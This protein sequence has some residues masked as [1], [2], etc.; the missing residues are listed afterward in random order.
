MATLSENP[1]CTATTTQCYTQLRKEEDS[2]F[3]KRHLTRVLYLNEIPGAM[4]KMG[5]TVAAKMMRHWFENKPWKMPP[6]DRGA[7]YDNDRN[8]PIIY[9]K[10]DP[11][12]INEDIITMKWARKF[13]RFEKVLKEYRP[14]WNISKSRQLL[15]QRLLE[16]GWR[17]GMSKFPLGIIGQKASVIENINQVN[18][19]T[20]GN[21]LDPLDDFY[22]A[23]FKANLHVAV[24][25]F[26]S[27]DPI[28]QHDMF[29]VTAVG[30]YIRDTYDFNEGNQPSDRMVN[31]TTGGLGIWS[32]DKM[33]DKTETA[34]YITSWLNPAV[35]LV[36]FNGFV[37][38]S[39]GDFYK[40]TDK[41]QKGGDF[42]VFSDVLWEQPLDKDRQFVIH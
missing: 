32:R 26:A 27:F 35:H 25:G 24:V 12:K 21:Y 19:K 2:T 7:Y 28:S 13:P 4:D 39:N 41:H 15:N 8:K 30:F 17:S 20:F 29:N 38:V 34:D 18:S 37:P 40:W 14:Q 42:Y 33:L 9:A 6:V 5:W 10:L 36:R 3:L 23:I 11:W 1:S 22:G 31:A 16:A